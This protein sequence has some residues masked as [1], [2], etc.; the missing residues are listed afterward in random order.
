MKIERKCE[1]ERVTL[2]CKR[3]DCGYK[4]KYGGYSKFYACCP[5]C[6]T[7]VRLTKDSIRGVQDAKDDQS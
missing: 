6:R 7:S 2:K 3:A 1:D 5:K 4:W